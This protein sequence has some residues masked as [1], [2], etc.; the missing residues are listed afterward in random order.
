[1]RWA[2][3]RVIVPNNLLIFHMSLFCKCL[4]VQS[5]GFSALK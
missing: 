2:N 3:A 1:M 5:L 4:K